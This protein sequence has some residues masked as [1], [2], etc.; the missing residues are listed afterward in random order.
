[1]RLWFL[2]LSLV[3]L[4]WALRRDGWMK[5][6]LVF[7]LVFFAAL[8]LVNW[9]FFHY[10]APVFGLFF[11]S[12]V[13]CMRH[14]RTWR[15]HGKPAG[16]FLARGSVILCAVSVLATGRDV[17][18]QYPDGWWAQ[19]QQIVDQLHREGGRH[20]IVIRYAPNVANTPS[21]G[22]R[23]WTRNGVDLDGSEILWAREMD[24]AH[25]A[26]LLE[27]F[28]D[29]RVWLLDVDTERHK[30]ASLSALTTADLTSMR[31]L[32][33]KLKHIG[34]AL[35][36]TPVI[37]AIRARYPD[38]E[39]TVVVRK[40]TEGILAGCPAIDRILTAAAPEGSR[41]SAL[42]WLEEARTIAE[43]RRKK[44]DYAFELSDGDRGRWVC[45]LAR[46]DVRCTNDSLIKLPR[47]WKPGF[48][49][50]LAF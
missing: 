17:A 23:D 47:I 8:L 49:K 38:A 24:A 5:F 27:Y 41:R 12:A 33:T 3:A 32:L 28:K 30:A 36:M 11:F 18:A 7:T 42:N 40:G 50:R 13:Q 22:Y 20:L 48:Q 19:R 21:F 16:L 1:M 39:I 34:D 44:F 45:A 37:M 35:L 9:T 10:A 15:W 6:A 25:N 46:A 31:I 2:T 14:L 26:R 29:R 4:P 43:L